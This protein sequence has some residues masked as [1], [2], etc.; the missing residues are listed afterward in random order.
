MARV[1]D[2]NVVL[3][4]FMGSGKTTV[5]QLVAREL[6]WTFVDT[7][8]VIVARHG[9]ID[10]IFAEQGEDAFRALEREVA[11]EVARSQH[12]V[13]ATGGRM[14]LDH[15]NADALTVTGRVFC[16][17]AD[18]DE[19]IRRLRADIDGPVRPLLSGED[20]AAAVARLLDERSAGYGQFEQ[21]RTAGRS[22]Q[23]I[24]AD[25]IERLE[26]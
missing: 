6:G 19:I 10:A 13:I 12:H 4:G 8:D 14:L 23:D 5:G 24:A 18:A 9:P 15:A 2:R 26:A 3:T 16:L 17:V 22:P 7:D 11:A 20:P 21:V 25:I 1:P